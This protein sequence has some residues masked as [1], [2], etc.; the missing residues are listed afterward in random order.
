MVFGSGG[1]F[2]ANVGGRQVIDLTALS[3]TQGF[4]IQ[5]DAAS[6]KAGFSVSSAGDVNGDGFEDLIVGAPYG[7]DGGTSA[8][9]AYVVFGS[10]GSFGAN[11]G[12]RQVI[13]LTALTAAQ[14]FIIQ[15]DAAFDFAGISVSSAG[16]VNGDGFE[17]LIVGARYGDDGGTSA[18]E[19]YVVFGGAFGSGSA[20]VTT[21]GSGAAEVLI[22]GLG[23]DTLTG[24]GGADVIRAGAGD[25]I[26]GVSD[27]TFKRIDGGSGDDTL[28]VDGTGVNLD[29]TS[30]LP[31]VITDIERIDLT[32]SGNNTLT[33]NQLDVFDITSA[34]SGGIA[35]LTVTG[36][37][38]DTVSFSDAGWSNV[39]QIVDGGITFNRYTNGNAE[40]RSQVGVTTNVAGDP[41]LL[42]LGTTG[43]TFAAAVNFDLN[44]DGTAERLTTWVG[45]E[46]G[47]LVMDSDGSGRIENGSEVFSP[48]FGAGN[49]FDSLAALSSL[50]SSNDGIFDANDAAFG[51]VLV[52]QDVNSDGISDAGEL[53]SLGDH[54]IASIDLDAQ[55]GG[56]QY[57]GVTVYA[58]GNFTLASGETR[59]FVEVGFQQDSAAGETLEG[60]FNWDGAGASQQ[61]MMDNGDYG[62]QGKIND[63]QLQLEISLGGSTVLTTDASISQDDWAHVALTQNGDTF[64]LYVDGVARNITGS[65]APN[66]LQSGAPEFSGTVDE[67]RIWDTVRTFAEINATINQSTNGNVL[68][69]QWDLNGNGSDGT[70]NTNNI[71]LQNGAGFENQSNITV[72]AGATFRALLLGEDADS[73]NLQY[74]LNSN[75][76]NG[77]VTQIGNGPEF[78]YINNGTLGANSF[79]VGVSD[80]GLTV[81]DTIDT[82]TV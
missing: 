33:L 58:E 5:G 78:T 10:G 14:G 69:A 8:G 46:D 61:V 42:D 75:T 72:P 32:G 25:D 13:D 77:T 40:L 9:E 43:L 82:T 49:Y 74:T 45:P 50:D 57:D 18:G 4:I 79:D 53:R 31:A 36:N 1:S 19:A 22:G 26:L 71:T 7:D 24:N 12:G 35:I 81:T 21:T 30:I 55:T 17:D 51:D 28:R 27:T 65:T 37:A 44:A 3:A 76:G 66:A 6:D 68:V 39:G 59:D 60:W 15:G 63:G 29:L 52:W 41:I 2:G 47:L 67:V 48:Y 56:A 62:V 64:E 16:D 54:G 38:G 70:T 20:S 34:R 23:N 73:T 80:G 11:V